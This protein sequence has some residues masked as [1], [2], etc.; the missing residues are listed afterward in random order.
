MEGKGWRGM[1]ERRLQVVF[2][3]CVCALLAAEQAAS[4]PKSSGS[5][6]RETRSVCAPGT[7]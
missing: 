5:V 3:A 4:M 6:Y 1:E 7:G 2:K